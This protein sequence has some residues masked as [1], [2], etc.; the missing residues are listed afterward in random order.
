MLTE[1]DL[2]TGDKFKAIAE[3]YGLVYIPTHETPKLLSKIRTQPMTEFGIVT[4]RSDGAILSPGQVFNPRPMERDLDFE[5]QNVPDNIKWW[6]CQNCDVKDD[7]L[8]PIPL[9]MEND[10]WTL[11]QNKKEI[12]ISLANVEIQ[13]RGTV[14]LNVNRATNFERPQIYHLLEEEPWCMTEYGKNGD[15]YTRYARMIRGHKFTLCPEGNGMCTHRFWEALYLGSFPIVRRRV[16][17]ESFAELLPILVVDNWSEVTKDFLAK[18]YQE[19][20]NRNWA[21]GALKIDY[22]EKLIRD[23]LGSQ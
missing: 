8:I 13:K 9:G 15:D 4:H 23:R 7:R 12:I 21:W 22:W 3:K 20:T 16:F 1:A 19:F 18:K 6:F 11:P 17:A 10:E 2:I 5:W 14:Y